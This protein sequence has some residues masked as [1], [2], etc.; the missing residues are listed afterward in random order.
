LPI[1][2]PFRCGNCKGKKRAG[3]QERKTALIFWSMTFYRTAIY[4]NDLFL[5]KY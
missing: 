4:Y 3:F 2:F 5:N 1:D